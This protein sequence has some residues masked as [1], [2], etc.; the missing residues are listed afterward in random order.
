MNK[1][2]CK[3][4]EYFK[5]ISVIHSTHYENGMFTL[6]C[7]DHKKRLLFEKNLDE[8]HEESIIYDLNNKRMLRSPV[9][10]TCFKEIEPQKGCPFYAEHFI[11]DLYK[12][13]K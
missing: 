7:S 10:L 2:V 11:Y 1:E 6:N 4:C 12:G 13:E 3:K 8:K 9:D 5:N